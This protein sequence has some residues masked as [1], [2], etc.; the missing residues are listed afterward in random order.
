[1]TIIRQQSP[2]TAL[3]GQQ[4]RKHMPQR[5]CIGCRT[6]Q[7]VCHLLRLACTPQG[8]IVLDFTGRIPGRGGYVCY[9]LTCLQKALHPAKLSRTFHQEVIPPDLHAAHTTIVHTLHTR[10]QRCLGMAQKA[11]AIVSGNETL[12]QALTQAT[13]QC[14]ILAEDAVATRVAAYQALCATMH[15][16]CVRVFSKDALGHCIG[17]SPRTALG[18]R[19]KHFC[20][21][22]C[23]TLQLLRQVQ[24]S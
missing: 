13:V 12:H 16:S 3:P 6:A 19:S 15:I 5:T 10:L 4:S 21:S 8:H 24:A 11:G 14:L 23:S 17:K 9:H 1:M 18:L 7:N 2:N 22:F 20:D